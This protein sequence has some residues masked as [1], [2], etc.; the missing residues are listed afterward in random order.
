MKKIISLVITV[1][2]I[3]SSFI[4]PTK[5]VALGKREPIPQAM[6]YEYLEVINS[7]IDK[8]GVIREDYE[9]LSSTNGLFYADLL[10]FDGD[11]IKEL[12]CICICDGGYKYEIWKFENDKV[13]NICSK[14][15]QSG[16]LREMK[17]VS[18]ITIDGKSHVLEKN[19]S[20]GYAGIDGAVLYTISGVKNDNWVEKERLEYSYLHLEGEDNPYRQEFAGQ[21]TGDFYYL[22]KNGERSSITEEE[23]NSKV[24]KYENNSKA[25][26]VTGSG[27][28]GTIEI[29]VD[30][31]EGNKN[32]QLFM[33]SLSSNL[34]SSNLK[35]VYGE[36][37]L[38]E[39]TRVIEFLNIFDYL[40]SFDINAIDQDNFSYFLRR[41]VN[42]NAD[43][44]NVKHEIIN[45][46][47]YY[48]V[49]E[50]D[51]LNITRKLFGIELL[52]K[53]EEYGFIKLN[54]KWYA[55]DTASGEFNY[56]SAQPVKMY[57][58][59]NGMYYVQINYCAIYDEYKDVYFDK[60]LLNI[61]MEKWD[62]DPGLKVN[63]E[64]KGY[65]I[66]KETM[67]GGKKG[68]N[69]LKL[70]SHHLL[71]EQ[72]IQKYIK[73]INPEP[74]ITFDYSKVKGFKES[75]EYISFFEETLKGLSGQ[76][77]ND[78]GNSQIVAYIQYA[79]ENSNITTVKSKGNKI[80]ID[81]SIIST[82]LSQAEKVK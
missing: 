41:Y 38:E 70:D 69:L 75:S 52:P 17:S 74:N 7:I 46:W 42:N 31:S 67:V 50:E 73:R 15:E 24:N 56:E 29:L 2:V 32:L 33:E 30:I 44:N 35:D 71:T 40:S 45:G 1:S 77:P 48:E 63:V 13:E 9:Y 21:E 64:H 81:N 47:T 60:D 6:A 28:A 3:L 59:G 20:F 10:D 55:G 51:M 80:T 12:F 68:Y 18:L 65:A 25:L 4:V 36:I 72:Q 39:K 16:V 58:L 82:A 49:K 53:I 8:Y 43:Y 62:L 78:S 34:I 37:S 22:A 14:Y 19:D 54:G 57:E 11:N 79:I 66:I 5:A 23:Y 61:P 76:K 27:G 26:L